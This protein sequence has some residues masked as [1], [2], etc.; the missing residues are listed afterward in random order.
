M[1]SRSRFRMP[2]PN[3]RKRLGPGIL[4]LT[5]MSP[6]PGRPDRTYGMLPPTERNPGLP[7]GRALRRAESRMTPPDD[8]GSAGEA[9]AII[10]GG[11]PA[12]ALPADWALFPGARSVD[13]PPHLLP[14]PQPPPPAQLLLG[15]AL[16][17]SLRRPV[18]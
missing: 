15:S 2:G 5:M 10:A 12:P 16:F 7:P 9:G 14:P 17:V 3:V 18:A 4:D 11:V 6:S 13:P 1:R 8:G